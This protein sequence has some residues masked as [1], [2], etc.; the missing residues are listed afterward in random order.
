MGINNFRKSIYTLIFLSL[1]TFSA[2][3]QISIT[4]D[5]ESGVYQIGETIHWTI[6]I[7]HIE[8]YD[9]I[10][11]A[12]KPGGYT[13]VEAKELSV[14]EGK[15]TLSYTFEQAGSVI[16]EVRWGEANN[17]FKRS[18]S[19]GI[20]A[21]ESFEPS[22]SKPKDFDAYW[23]SKLKELAHIPMNAQI[24]AASIQDSTIDY[25]KVKMDNIRNSKIYGQLAK[26]SHA[27]NL[28]ALLIVQWA[29]VYPLCKDWVTRHA[30][31]GWLVLN[32]NPHDLPIDQEEEFYKDQS[33]NAL[34][35]Y[36]S[37]GNESRYSSYFLRMYLSCYRAVEYLKQHPSWNGKTLAVMGDS[38]GGQQSLMIAGL[39]PDIT[40][41]MALVPAGFDML[42]PELGRKGGWPQW[43]DQTEGKDADEV[44]TA[45]KYFDVTH[46]IPNIKCPVLVG[47][48]LLDETCPPEG[49][50]AGLN[51]LKSNKEI[52]L[53]PLSQH[54][55][56]TGK[57]Q[58]SYKNKR[59]REWLPK[60]KKG[61]RPIN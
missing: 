22:S 16:L 34:K 61:Q 4:T 3:C 48:G 38:Q 29:G 18:V 19:G 9:S 26:P 32:I 51:Q 13:T 17:W 39:H 27:E 7:E 21:P 5:H 60:L 37:I 35:N 6:S 40:A 36:W 23:Q 24:T 53:L 49:I 52:I 28:P 55:D 46:F 31:E 44:H 42:G 25:A 15:A 57:T 45:S 12:I 11:Y 59:D 41:A 43:Y 10:R 54:Q 1:Y 58:A 30:K 20:C 50:L 8:R 47:V 2:F 33:N 56:R 14:E